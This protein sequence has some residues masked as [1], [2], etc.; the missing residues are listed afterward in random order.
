MRINES[1]R[2]QRIAPRG[3]TWRQPAALALF[4]AFVACVAPDAMDAGADSRQDT[5]SYA[6]PDV[7]RVTHVALDLTADFDAHTLEGTAK[8][9][10]QRWPDADSIVLDVRDLTIEAVDDANGDPLG[11]RLGEE[12]PYMGAPL[13][14]ELPESGDTIVV[15]YQTSPDA[16]A[17]QWLAPEQTAGGEQPYL[18]TQGQAILTRTW[19]PTQDSPGIRQTYEA[20]IVVPRGL[21][22]VMSAEMLTPEGEPA[23]AA[24]GPD[25]VPQATGQRAAVAYRFRMDNPLS[26]RTTELNT[27]S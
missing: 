27:S 25:S 18:F 13:I 14:V 8:L 5:H 4:V 22:A 6:Q 26:S 21:R 16:A 2:V 20:R 11:F 24:G 12:A 15:R 19:I 1:R 3:L 10:I 23:A 17:V 9:A 7:A